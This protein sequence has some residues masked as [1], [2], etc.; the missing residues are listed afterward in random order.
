MT[1]SF[2]YYSHVLMQHPWG[3]IWE[4]GFGKVAQEIL[5]Y[6]E[7]WGTLREQSFWAELKGQMCSR[8]LGLGSR[9]SELNFRLSINKRG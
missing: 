4:C 3:I 9:N 5:V 7:L 2:S 1:P 6:G 8:V